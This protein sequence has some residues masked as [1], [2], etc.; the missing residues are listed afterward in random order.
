MKKEYFVIFLLPLFWFPGKAE[1]CELHR[2]LK[3][4]NKTSEFFVE[5][6]EIQP[7][8]GGDCM[9]ERRWEKNQESYFSI[10]SNYGPLVGRKILRKALPYF[11]ELKQIENNQSKRLCFYFRITVSDSNN[12]FFIYFSEKV[13]SDGKCHFLFRDS[14]VLFKALF[15][16]FSSYNA[17]EFQNYRDYMKIVSP[18]LSFRDRLE[19]YYFLFALSG[20]TIERFLVLFFFGIF[21]FLIVGLRRR[22]GHSWSWPRRSNRQDGR[23]A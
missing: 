2:L 9:Y 11:Q 1:E 5:K 10:Q 20:W 12:S 7:F 22:W 6:F 3:T 14:D 13:L 16:D 17:F 21:I 18:P 8:W 23:S 4:E 19:H 15:F